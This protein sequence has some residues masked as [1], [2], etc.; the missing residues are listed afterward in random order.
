MSL[1]Q[2][3]KKLSSLGFESFDLFGQ[4]SKQTVVEELG[5]LC[6]ALLELKGESSSITISDEV[7]ATY[8]RC[9][10]D[11]KL[12]FFQLLFAEFPVSPLALDEAIADYQQKRDQISIQ[13]L[14]RVAESPRQELFRIL[15]IAPEAT[16]RLVMMRADLLKL[17]RDYPELEAINQDMLHLFHSWFNRGFLQLRRIDWQTPALVLEKLMEYES[18]HEVRGWPDLRRRLESDRRCYA[19]FHPVIPDT[20]LIFVE[21]ALT[22][23]ITA[24]I[25]SLLDQQPQTADR[26]NED[27]ADFDTAV[28]YSINNCLDGLRGVS[29]GS[30]LIKQVVESLADSC[31]G[32]SN[33]VTL[34]PVP[35][36]HKWLKTTHFETLG[37]DDEDNQRLQALL[38]K[39][40]DEAAL[41]EESELQPLLVRLCA[42][43]LVNE[44]SRGKP[45]DPVARF[46]LGNG[47]QLERINWLADTSANGLQQAAGIMVNYLYDRT[48]LADNHE[49]YETEDAIACSTEVKKLAAASNLLNQKKERKPQSEARIDDKEAEAIA[50]KT[51]AEETALKEERKTDEADEEDLEAP[52]E[53][54]I[55]EESTTEDSVGDEGATLEGVTIEGVAIE[56]SEEDEVEGQ[57]KS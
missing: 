10:D 16:Y 24:T 52:N 48:R 30:F 29:F 40:L 45:A 17:L 54:R 50:S 31:P 2:L 56:V 11:E 55:A 15:N 5:Q 14:S 36:F 4:R 51:A 26:Q 18:V 8:H 28:F 22:D 53:V 37:L 46:H 57:H 20:P 7:L 49:A 3:L 41:V 44:K 25:S 6:R 32:I 27:T 13:H 47:A 43:Y 42:H 35:G 39:E 21:V 1:K 19:F 38:A 9:S 23:E 34:S 12:R 33:F